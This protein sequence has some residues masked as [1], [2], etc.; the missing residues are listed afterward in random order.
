M[1]RMLT[2][3]LLTAG[4]VLVVAVVLFGRS[5]A[6]AIKRPRIS[7]PPA[8]KRHA[9]PNFQ[10]QTVSGADVSL[11]RYRGQPLVI[12]FFA[13]WCLPC[14]EEAPQLVQLDRRYGGRVHLLSVA[15]RTSQRSNLDG[16]IRTHKVT[17]PVVWDRSGTMADSYRIP[18]QPIT[19]IIDS[20][21]RVVYRILGQI[22]EPEVGSVLNRLLA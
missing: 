13:A 8:S 18:V 21:G 16:F 19:M 11:A 4:S 20:Q 2:V 5:H 9:A 10:E 6:D 22:T 15:V 17:W 1:R 3:A 7:I 14:K 12:N